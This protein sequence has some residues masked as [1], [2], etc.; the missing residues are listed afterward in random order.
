M[1]YSLKCLSLLSALAVAAP[2]Y[3]NVSLTQTAVGSSTDFAGTSLNGGGLSIDTLNAGLGAG[4]TIAGGQSQ[5]LPGTST[6]AGEVFYW[7]GGDS[8]LNAI[9]FINTGGGG[10]GTYQPYL[11]DLG[12]SASPVYVDTTHAF[13]PNNFPNLFSGSLSIQPPAT[14]SKQFEELDFSGSDSVTLQTGHSYAWG[15]VVGATADFNFERANGLHTYANGDSYTDTSLTATGNV[16]PSPYSGTGV[17]DWFMGIYTTAVPEPSSI[18]LL[19]LG[20]AGL[21]IR[22]RKA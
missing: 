13:I 3:A 14:G 7:N 17:R 10:V 20:L 15:V 8:A 16:N 12:F 1:K 5:G 22:Q 6:I 18:A 19:G 2:A 21:L 9:T 4:G 11:L